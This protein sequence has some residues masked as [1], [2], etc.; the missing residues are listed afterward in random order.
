MSYAPTWSAPVSLERSKNYRLRDGLS[1]LTSH[2]EE[3]YQLPVD[4]DIE[5]HST[6]F[7]H[8]LRE[9]VVQLVRELL[10]N[11]VKHAGVRP[12]PLARQRKRW[13]GSKSRTA[14]RASM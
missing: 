14:D 7:E 1:W 3:R 4:V 2:M 5:E 9:L 11:V 8:E 6:L 10:F 13:V 12:H